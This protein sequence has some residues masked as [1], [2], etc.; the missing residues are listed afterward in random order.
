MEKQLTDTTTA[1]VT[2]DQELAN[3]LAGMNGQAAVGPDANA[4]SSDSTNPGLQ[5]EETGSSAVADDTPPTDAASTAP[6]LDELEKSVAADTAA[7]AAP[8]ETAAPQLSPELDSLKKDAVAELRP[9][10]DKL[11]LPAAEKFDTLLLII[12]ST[13]DQSLLPGAHEAAKSIEDDSKRAQALLDVIKEIDYF[14][15]QPK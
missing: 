10:V 7:E 1:P 13:D 6:T 3:V 9:L 11:D 4:P 14:A 12:R 8:A 15:N 5:Y 2:D